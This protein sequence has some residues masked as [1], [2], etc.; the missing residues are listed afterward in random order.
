MCR[1]RKSTDILHDLNTDNKGHSWNFLIL[2]AQLELRRIED[3]AVQ[4]R[5]AIEVF[6]H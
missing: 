4:L 1:R 3:R 6:R 2:S 5:E